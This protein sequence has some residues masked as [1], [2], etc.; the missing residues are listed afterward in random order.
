MKRLSVPNAWMW[1]YLT[2]AIPLA[3]TAIILANGFARTVE[4]FM[5]VIA[6]PSFM[7]FIMWRLYW[8]KVEDVFD[9]GDSILVRSGN[10]KVV[11][12]LQDIASVRLV[13]ERSP[14][15]RIDLKRKT[16]F[17]ARIDFFD[18]T[19]YRFFGRIQASEGVQ[20]LTSR[21]PLRD[22]SPR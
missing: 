17:G 13:K 21:I 19:R 20:R 5:V 15:I 1:K 12:A 14:F 18:G 6:F 7:L 4:S 11:I 10:K 16:V 3:V 2:P 8:S 22:A 9:C